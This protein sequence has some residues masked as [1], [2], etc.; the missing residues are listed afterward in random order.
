ML[1]D[2]I[3]ATLSD[4]KGSLTSVILK[5]K[6][7]LHSIGKKDLATWVTHELKG[8]PDEESIPEYRR[9]SSEV[10]GK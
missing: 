1:L 6:V 10:H 9:I 7:L 5:T 8:Y 3:I 4:E 2:E